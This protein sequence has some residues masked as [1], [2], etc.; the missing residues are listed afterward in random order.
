MRRRQRL[1]EH[2]SFVPAQFVQGQDCRL[3][4]QRR[5]NRLRERASRP[6]RCGRHDRQSLHPGGNVDL[7]RPLDK[8]DST[9]RGQFSQ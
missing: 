6:L 4:G 2:G 3:P 7:R 5:R 1:P 9:G 8:P